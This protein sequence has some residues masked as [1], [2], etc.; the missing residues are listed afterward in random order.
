[1]VN[2]LS[3]LMEQV[4]SG[5]IFDNFDN[6]RSIVN[7]WQRHARQ[8]TIEG[9]QKCK[10]AIGRANR[11]YDEG[12]EE[13][14]DPSSDSGEYSELE[15]QSSSSDDGDANEESRLTILAGIA[16]ATVTH[17]RH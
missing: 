3:G 15:A 13:S 5:T 12:P 9:Q 7:S 14:G 2:Q 17:H 11:S 8:G 4:P 16:L 1:M 6:L 10:G